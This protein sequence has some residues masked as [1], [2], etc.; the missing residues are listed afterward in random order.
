MDDDLEAV[1]CRGADGVEEGDD[2]EG[3]CVKVEEGD[4]EGRNVGLDDDGAEVTLF[5]SPSR[6]KCL[7]IF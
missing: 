7:F 3:F 6:R 4:E 2:L 1:A 5:I